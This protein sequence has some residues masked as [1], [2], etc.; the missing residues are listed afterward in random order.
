MVCAGG[1]GGGALPMTSVALRGSLGPKSSADVYRTASRA[2]ASGP[3]ASTP[4]RGRWNT[5][6]A[7]PANTH[8]INNDPNTKTSKSALR[9][10]DSF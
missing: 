4:T 3:Q 6:F 10:S 7:P 9:R 8:H 2:G 1:G 5:L